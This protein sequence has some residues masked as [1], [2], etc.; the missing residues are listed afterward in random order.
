MTNVFVKFD[1]E[2]RYCYGLAR[3]VK[4]IVDHVLNK[5]IRIY[6]G[7]MFRNVNISKIA[8]SGQYKAKAGWRLKVMKCVQVGNKVPR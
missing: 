1:C 5:N 7:K 4:G 3:N 2:Y 6:L 8:A